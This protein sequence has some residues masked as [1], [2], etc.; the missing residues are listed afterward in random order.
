MTLR[1][2]TGLRLLG[3]T[4]S[5]S[6][7]LCICL[8]LGPGTVPVV[9]LAPA[10]SFGKAGVTAAGGAVWNPATH[11]LATRTRGAAHAAGKRAARRRVQRDSM[12]SKQR[13]RLVVLGAELANG[14]GGYDQ[15]GK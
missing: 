15:I 5:R 3:R 2:H 9:T 11:R 10:G 12:V 7:S 4:V 6:K 14:H 8:D 1:V 13:A